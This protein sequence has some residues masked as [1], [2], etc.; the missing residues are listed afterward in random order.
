MIGNFVAREMQQTLNWGLAAAMGTMLLFAV[1]ALYWV[2][3]K[4]IGID[5]LKMV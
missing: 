1:L 2:Y 3:D 5:N 4:F